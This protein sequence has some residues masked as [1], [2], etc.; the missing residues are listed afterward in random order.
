[1][2]TIRSL[3][4]FLILAVV[5]AVFAQTSIVVRGS[6][7]MILLGQKCSS[8][9]TADHPEIKI[10]VNGGGGQNGLQALRAHTADIV[11]FSD[12]PTDNHSS[13]GLLQVPVAVE[14]VVVFVNR[15]NPVNELTLA[16]LRDIYTG[17]ISNWKQVGGHDERI[18]LYS[19][20][21][22]VNG[23][24]FFSEVVLGGADF[25]TTMRGY[26]RAQDTWQA[27]AADPKGIGFGALVDT[28][29]TKRLLI[30]KAKGSPAV[31]PTLD[32]LRHGTFPLSRR[33]Y[34]VLSSS[35]PPARAFAT[36][37]VSWQGQI[38]VA[39]TGYYPLGPDDRRSATEVLGTSSRR[40]N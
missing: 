39:S 40:G 22:A 16:Q 25:D 13:G 5:P 38:V 32:N 21:A 10:S 31:A 35:A 3:F 37:V 4:I 17:K 20:E 8:Q 34:W 19:T 1:M 27:V 28:T 9:F 6:D 7:A 36:W 23:S 2:R 24:L 30:A 12:L 11:Q 14:G 33:L 18:Q 29:N 26:N 15:S